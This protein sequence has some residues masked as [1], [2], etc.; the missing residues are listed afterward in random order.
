M[1]RL[2]RGTN[3]NAEKQVS[4][5]LSLGWLSFDLVPFILKSLE[6]I[7]IFFSPA[8]LSQLYDYTPS[9]TP[10]PTWP[11]SRYDLGLVLCDT[12]MSS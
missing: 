5:F 3:H 7:S 2:N 8:W 1:K 9:S 11:Y 4:R 6:Q 12:L 10:L